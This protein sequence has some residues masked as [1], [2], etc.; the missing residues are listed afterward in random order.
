M[1]LEGTV[2]PMRQFGSYKDIARLPLE[3][4]RKQLRDPVFCARVLADTPKVPCDETTANMIDLGQDVHPAEPISA[5]SRT[6]PSR[7]PA[8]RRRRAS[9]CAKP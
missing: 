8:S 1:S 5:M 9:M 3:E 6:W 4:Q 2:N 7:W